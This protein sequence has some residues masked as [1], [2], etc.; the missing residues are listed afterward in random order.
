MVVRLL[1]SAMLLKLEQLSKA[2]SPILVI[3]LGRVTLVK[4]V[5]PLKAEGPME[6]TLLGITT[7]VRLV[8]PEKALLPILVTG[9][10]SIWLGIVTC[11][12]P[13][14]PV[15]VMVPLLVT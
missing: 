12:G 1:G 3:L 8:K 14:Y 2:A 6:V 9:R 13:T 15:I 11:P 4:G 10:P 7:S 5:Q